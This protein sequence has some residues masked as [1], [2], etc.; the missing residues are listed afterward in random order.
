MMDEHEI[1]HRASVLPEQFAS[2]LA[3][4]TIEFLHLMDQGGEYG[5]LV[6][7]LTAALVADHTVVT[8]AE[9]D[10]LLALLQATGMPRN[11]IDQLNID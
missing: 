4:D 5:E 7:E 11:H 8:H 3:G 10:E 9:K 1:A 2:R 6:A